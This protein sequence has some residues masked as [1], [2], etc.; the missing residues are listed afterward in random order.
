MLERGVG[1]VGGRGRGDCGGNGVAREFG[2]LSSRWKSSGLLFIHL[3]SIG[4]GAF[5]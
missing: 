3:Y 1:G 5:S 2:C 4:V